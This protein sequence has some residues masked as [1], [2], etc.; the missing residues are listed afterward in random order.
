MANR[1]S[2]EQQ[3]LYETLLT[4]LLQCEDFYDMPQALIHPDFVPENMIKIDVGDWAVVDWAGA[5]IGPRIWSLGFLLWAAGLRGLECVDVVATG[6]RK[7]IS[8]DQE[9]LLQLSNAI[10]IRPIIFNCWNFCM[11]RKELHDVVQEFSEIHNKAKV[12]ALRSI[13]ALKS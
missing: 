3:S 4:E 7:Y 6:Y 8:L 5:G 10:E 9:E 2:E 1:I 13:Q 12:V 11:G